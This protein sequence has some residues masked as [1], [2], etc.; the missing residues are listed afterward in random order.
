MRVLGSFGPQ[1]GTTRAILGP[2]AGLMV[3]REPFLDASRQRAF[4][5]LFVARMLEGI[6]HYGA[7]L[8]SS[9]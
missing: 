9:D 4:P 3:A 8:S 2:I 7:E 1:C 5:Y 6:G